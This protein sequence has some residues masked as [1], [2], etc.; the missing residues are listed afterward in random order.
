MAL[1]WGNALWYW[2]N[3]NHRPNGALAILGFDK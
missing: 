3:A 2:R 1:A